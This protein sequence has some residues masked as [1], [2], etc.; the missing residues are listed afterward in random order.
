MNASN[1]LENPSGLMKRFEKKK[2]SK[3]VSKR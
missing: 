2:L 3:R 1:L